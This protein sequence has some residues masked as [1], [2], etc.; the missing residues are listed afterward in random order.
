VAISRIEANHDIALDVGT[1]FTRIAT[2]DEGLL[3]EEP[4]IVAIDTR[5]GDVVAVGHTAREAVVSF[6]RHVVAYRPLEAGAT[7][8]FDVTARLIRALVDKSQV[9]GFSRSK[10]IMGVPAHATS[11]ERRALRQAAL[12]AGASEATL[13][14]SPIAAAVGLGLPVA[15][16]VASAVLTLGAGS[17]EASVI[18]LG[19]IVSRRSL[20]VGGNNIDHNIATVIRQRFD[21]VVSLATAEWIKHELASAIRRPPRSYLSVPARSIKDGE[22]VQIEVSAQLIEP[23]VE[24]V[25]AQ[26]IR[27][28]TE[29]LGEAPP[30]LVHDVLLHGVAVVGGHANLR[31]STA[32]FESEL[33]ARIVT[34]EESERV[35]IDGL[36]L[37]L[38]E[39]ALR[40]FVRAAEV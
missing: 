14:E 18:S 1:S 35:V 39:R 27:M 10:V 23:V 28:A 22:P 4:S 26:T 25:V 2:R 17:S 31:D 40:R 21:V 5:N 16:P 30:D 11:I 8:D 6:P 20:R 13:I 34:V 3:I 37:C 38:R 32:V 36:R 19:G 24:D 15:E 12:Q 9:R 7:V 29:A 33:G